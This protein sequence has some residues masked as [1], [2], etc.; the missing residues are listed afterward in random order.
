MTDFT[1]DFEAG[2]NGAVIAAT[3]PGS[4]TQWVT[5]NGSPIY[6]TA[7][8]AH[9][10]KAAKFTAAGQQLIWNQSDLTNS[11]GRAY[12]YG[13]F[14]ASGGDLL[15]T[16]NSIDATIRFT[17]LAFAAQLYLRDTGSAHQIGPS[18]NVNVNG[19]FRIEWHVFHDPTVGTMELKLF[20]TPDATSPDS[21]IT[22]S[23][24]CNTGTEGH[25][26]LYEVSNNTTA[27]LDDLLANATAYPGPAGSAVSTPGR[28]IVNAGNRW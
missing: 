20:N 23:A 25:Q 5:V 28:I 10:T 22:S 13:D 19:W 8:A 27:W 16:I 12:I 4:L 6:D 11:Y 7:H 17:I 18:A 14:S 26:I 3:D 24:N 2:S 9:G 1:A 21:T 15:V